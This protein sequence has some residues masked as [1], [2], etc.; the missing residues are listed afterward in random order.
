MGGPGLMRILGTARSMPKVDLPTDKKILVDVEAYHQLLSRACY[1]ET[2]RFDPVVFVKNTLLKIFEGHDAEFFFNGDGNAEKFKTAMQRRDKTAPLDSVEALIVTME[3]PEQLVSAGIQSVV[4]GNGCDCAI[5]PATATLLRPW[6]CKR[7]LEYDINALLGKAGLSRV[8]YQALGVV[9]HTDYSWNISGLGI[10]NNNRILKSISKDNDTLQTLLQS[11]NVHP[12][13][14]IALARYHTQDQA[15]RSAKPLNQAA[16]L[17]DRMLR[18]SGTRRRALKAMKNGQQQHRRRQKKYNRFRTVNGPSSPPAPHSTTTDIP[19]RQIDHWRIVE[20]RRSQRDPETAT[21]AADCKAECLAHGF[22]KLPS[23]QY[24]IHVH[25][26]QDA[27]AS[28]DGV[29][30]DVP[31]NVQFKLFK[32]YASLEPLKPETLN[33]PSKSTPRTGPLSRTDT[34]KSISGFH[35][36]TTLAIGQLGRNIGVTVVPQKM[37]QMISQAGEPPQDRKAIVE[38]A[39]TATI[40]TIRQEDT[41]GEGD[42]AGRLLGDLADPEDDADESGTKGD[43]TAFTVHP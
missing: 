4:L 40:K 12:E 23:K 29:N 8:Q 3:Q 18:A 38:D 31:E 43:Q 11:Y 25:K 39:K 36:I 30:P 26:V 19:Q 17:K 5:H 7:F 24:G 6:G 34:I 22:D 32:A 35:Q 41:E 13:V 37:G 9:S 2:D 33:Q 14:Q 21:R 28:N 15:T 42:D 27:P 20:E 1:N 16:S 10:G